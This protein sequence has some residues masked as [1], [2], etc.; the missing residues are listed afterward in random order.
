VERYFGVGY[1]T[2]P[3]VGSRIRVSPAKGTAIRFPDRK[4][5]VTSS[6]REWDV[7]LVRLVYKEGR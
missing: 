4:L 3:A 1:K 5:S 6:S 2:R 7:D